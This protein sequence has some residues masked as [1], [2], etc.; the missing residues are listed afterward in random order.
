M[1]RLDKSSFDTQRGH[2]RAMSK[3]CQRQR[4]ISRV[5]ALCQACI[6]RDEQHVVLE[7]SALQ[8]V[9]DRYNGLLEDHVAT[10]VRVHVA[11]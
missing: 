7:C 9:G 2:S 8:G 1:P 10:L 4:F 6:L 11:N 5:R 3:H